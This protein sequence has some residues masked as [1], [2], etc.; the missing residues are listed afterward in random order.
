MTLRHGEEHIVLCRLK[1]LFKYISVIHATPVV[2][3]THLLL[4]LHQTVLRQCDATE[5]HK[6]FNNTGSCLE[7]EYLHGEFC[8]DKCPPGNTS[9]ECL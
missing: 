2:F 1:I 5:G 4:C 6:N 8:C 3:I 9:P 7:N